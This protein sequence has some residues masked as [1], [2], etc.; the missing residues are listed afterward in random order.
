MT[1]KSFHSILAPEVIPQTW[2]NGGTK[3]VIITAMSKIVWQYRLESNVQPNPRCRE[4]FLV[5][6][7]SHSIKSFSVLTVQRTKF[8]DRYTNICAPA[9]NSNVETIK[10]LIRKYLFTCFKL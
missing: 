1:I 10:Y 6:T 5:H 4:T 2:S 8:I 9:N 3:S 7:I